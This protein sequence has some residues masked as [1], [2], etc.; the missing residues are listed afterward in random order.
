MVWVGFGFGFGLSLFCIPSAS[1]I[2][3]QLPLPC[4][5]FNWQSLLGKK[6]KFPFSWEWKKDGAEVAFSLASVS[7][8]MKV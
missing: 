5:F 2:S 3:R 1:D 7:V 8:I 4:F 6:S